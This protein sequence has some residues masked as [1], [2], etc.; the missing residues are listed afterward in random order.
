MLLAT[1]IVA[2]SLSAFPHALNSNSGIANANI[3][4][5]G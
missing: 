1:V 3:I 4:F 2:F 5:A